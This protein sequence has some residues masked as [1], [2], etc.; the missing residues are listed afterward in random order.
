MLDA[1]KIHPEDDVMVALHDLPAGTEVE[2][3]VLLEDVKQAHKF[4]IH[5]M[6]AGELLHKYGNVIGRLKCD[7]KKGQW[8]HSVE[9]GTAL[10]EAPTYHYQKGK[11]TPK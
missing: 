8:I 2:G 1:V 6:K 7:V 9:L 5:D 11:V 4:A 10:D 3:I